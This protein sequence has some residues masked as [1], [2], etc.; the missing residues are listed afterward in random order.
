MIQGRTVSYEVRKNKGR[1][2][3][4]KIVVMTLVYASETSRHETK[5]KCLQCIQWKCV[6]RQVV[7]GMSGLDDESNESILYGRFAK[8]WRLESMR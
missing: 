3:R 6:I 2:H 5:E 1:G 4:N 8:C 7:Y